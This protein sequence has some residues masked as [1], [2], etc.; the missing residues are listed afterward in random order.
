VLR[1]AGY[2]VHVASAPSEAIALLMQGLRPDVLLT[3]VV[4]PEM[5]GPALSKMVLEH[6]RSCRTVFMSGYTDAGIFRLGALPAGATFIGKPFTAPELTG[7]IA[8]LFAAE[9]T[10]Q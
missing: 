9:P 10:L 2:A 4:L 6:C 1:K 7:A 3:D 5:N 8:A